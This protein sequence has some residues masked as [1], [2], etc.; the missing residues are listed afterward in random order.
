MSVM[1][2][3]FRHESA[4]NYV[5]DAPSRA[6]DGVV[7]LPGLGILESVGLNAFTNGAALFVPV[8]HFAL[9]TDLTLQCTQPPDKIIF[10]LD[11]KFPPEE[12]FLTCMRQH[13]EKGFTFAIENVTDFE[14]MHP[15]VELCKFIKLGFRYDMDSLDIFNKVQ[16]KYRKHVFIATDVNTME[17]FTKLQRSGFYYFEGRFYK[18]PVPQGDNAISPLKVNRIQLLNIVREED[19]DVDEVVTVVSRDP[20]MSI[21]LLK[22]VNSPHLGISQQI[23]GIQQAV[24][25]LGQAEVRKWVTTA[26]SGLLAEDKPS[27]LTRLSL[28]RAKF[29]E[30]MAKHFEMA[31]HSNS[32]FLM[33]LFSIIDAA[34]NMPMEE[35]LEMVQV[36]DDVYSA[37]VKGEGKFM[38]LLDFIKAYEAA[39]WNSCKNILTLNNIDP[40]DVFNAYI[41]TVQW[42]DTII[43]TIIDEPEEETDT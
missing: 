32:L 37:L 18:L 5:S 3:T 34:L 23:K 20:S 33:G 22:L 30:N 27:E 39:D 43:S 12:P 40:G 26:I 21:S 38:P 17:V 16:R 35:A 41:G 29:A 25:L 36:T 11:N 4:H 42:Y 10:L 1:A 8:S 19:F 15:V 2:Y 6:F 7:S 31:M 24:A 13:I 9:L 28:L 14:T